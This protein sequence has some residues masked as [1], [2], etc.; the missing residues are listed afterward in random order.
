MLNIPVSKIY[1]IEEE[2]FIEIVKNSYSKNECLRKI[3]LSHG[4]SQNDILDKR[5]SELNISTDHFK[6]LGGKSQK[7]YTFEDI[8]KENSEYTN[9]GRIKEKILDNKLMEYKCAICGNEGE[10]LGKPL[11]LQLDHIDGNHTNHSLNNLRFL[12]PNCHTQTAT[13]GS[14][15]RAK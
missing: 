1:Q 5:I 11:I 2:Q 15:S 6:Y 8:F 4:R 12:C 13:Y 10:W 7:V 3:G 9:L 14:K